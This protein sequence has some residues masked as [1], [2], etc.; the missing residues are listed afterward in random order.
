MAVMS[1]SLASR[2]QDQRAA[3]LGGA[4]AALEVEPPGVPR[5]R[6]QHQ[7]HDP[8]GCGGAQRHRSGR[9]REGHQ[10]TTIVTTAVVRPSAATSSKLP[11]R[12]RP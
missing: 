10:H 8:R 11:K 6:H 9:Q 5:G 2:A 3:G 1:W 4:Q 12:Q 7:R